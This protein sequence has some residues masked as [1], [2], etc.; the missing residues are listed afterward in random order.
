MRDVDVPLSFRTDHG[1][2]DQGAGTIEVKLHIVGLADSRNHLAGGRR[3]VSS[4]KLASGLIV[5]GRVNA[6]RLLVCLERSG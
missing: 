1:P 6:G 5:E 3:S 4:G 2:G